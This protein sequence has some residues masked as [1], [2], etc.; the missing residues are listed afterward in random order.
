MSEVWTQQ[1]NKCKLIQAAGT[2]YLPSFAKYTIE[3]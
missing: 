2:K 1:K 3:R